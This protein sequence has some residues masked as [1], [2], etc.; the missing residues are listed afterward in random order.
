M[1]Y[2]TQTLEYHTH[3]HTQKA[4][5]HTDYFISKIAPRPSHQP[6]PLQTVNG[7]AGCLLEEEHPDQ[8]RNHG[9]V[10]RAFGVVD[11]ERTRMHGNEGH[12]LPEP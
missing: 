5:Y 3:H 10:L 4:G 7:R 9:S 8:R 11:E 2:H 6:T 1:A 12:E